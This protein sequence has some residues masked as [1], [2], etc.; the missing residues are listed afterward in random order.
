ED[1]SFFVPHCNERTFPKFYGSFMS[2]STRATYY[3]FMMEGWQYK[4]AFVIQFR[5]ETNIEAGRFEGRVEQV[6]SQKASRFHSFDE[7][8]RFTES[9]VT[10][11]PHSEQ[12]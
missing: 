9:V 3:P 5:P 12:P 11:A 8:L 10:K 7:L 4:A 1:Y 6:A 2:Y